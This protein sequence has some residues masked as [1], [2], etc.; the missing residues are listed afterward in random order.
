[1]SAFNTL[2][3]VPEQLLATHDRLR[4]NGFSV[5]SVVNARSQLDARVWLGQ[6]ARAR[7][8][9]L[10]LAP[11]TRLEAAIAVLAGPPTISPLRALRAIRGDPRRA[12]APS[13][14]EIAVSTK[15]A[16]RAPARRRNAR[17]S[18]VICSSGSFT[19]AGNFVA[20]SSSG[21]LADMDEAA[22]DIAK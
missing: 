12:P 16:E 9:P 5:V 20:E 3:D 4:T 13:R 22:I 1:M 7:G 10:I 15:D 21:A 2:L 17:F 19:N 18:A 11:E 14:A 8:R 6:W